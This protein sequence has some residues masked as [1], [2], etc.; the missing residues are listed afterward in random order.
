ML[1]KANDV[2]IMMGD[3][4]YRVN[5]DCTQIHSDIAEG[6]YEDLLKND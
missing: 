3:L 6:V 2:V 4:N 5:G 1:K